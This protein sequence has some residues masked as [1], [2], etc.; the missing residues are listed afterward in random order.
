MKSRIAP[1]ALVAL[2]CLCLAPLG[3]QEVF[4]FLSMDS[5]FAGEAGLPEFARKS[6]AEFSTFT[7]SNGIPVIV[8][9]NGGNR[10]QHIS[11]IL[12]G[13]TLL[14]DPA[15]AGLESLSLA[16]MARASGT[17]PYAE[18]QALLDATSSSI[19][20][21]S[22]FEYSSYSLN[23]LDKYFPRLFPVWSETLVAPA[24]KA[25]DF[26]QAL[27]EAKLA[28]QSKEQDPWSKTVLVMNA[29]FF[30]GH[31]YSITPEGT[32]ESLDRMSLAA[33]QDWYAAK[34][35]AERMFIVAVGDFDVKLLRSQ[36]ESGIGTIPRLS[37]QLPP[38]P[39]LFAG[40]A[41]SR[42]VSSE[43]PQSK[44]IAYIRG[45]FPTPAPRDADYMPLE[46]AM[47]MLRDLLFNVMRDKYGATYSPSAGSRFFNA[48]YG[49][50]YVYKTK[51][52]AKA[53]AYL[54]EAVASLAEG[55][56]L[57]VD[58]TSSE[59]TEPRMT[60]E[61]A[62]PVYK[63]LYKTYH[64]E[65][66]Q[67]NAAV[68]S[69]IADSVMESGDYRSYL[70]DTGRVD[71]VTA[72]EVRSAFEK[73]VLGGKYVWVVLGSRDAIQDVKAADYAGFSA[74]K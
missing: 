31:P 57:S 10:I 4:P 74:S 35:A 63:A 11:L 23:T 28:L 44:G 61:A 50:F 17:H 64:Y 53:K 37:V 1:A 5:S 6:L 47:Q 46:I 71:A 51:V 60:V 45:D 26:D 72:P 69:L 24:L 21:S 52:A 15:M 27:S 65:S 68:A 20:S 14:A 67:T 8:K 59:G 38:P 34:F 29:E 22:T 13:G 66:Q 18:I 39:P 40:P 33:V 49:S 12:R 42:L 55:K 36:L 70:L 48:N 25:S 54:D 41:A 32:K 58:P 16:T 62:L 19:G 2:V 7:L 73:Y 3:A 30:A 43:Y 56:C 9:H